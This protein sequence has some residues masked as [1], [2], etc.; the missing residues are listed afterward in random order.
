MG[1]EKRPHKNKSVPTFEPAPPR[2]GGLEKKKYNEL[3]AIYPAGMP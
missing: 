2:P 3:P 1:A